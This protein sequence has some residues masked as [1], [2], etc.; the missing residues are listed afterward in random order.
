MTLLSDKLCLAHC[1]DRCSC[2]S[3]HEYFPKEIL[4]KEV[5]LYAFE[6]GDKV[7]KFTGDYHAYGEVRGYVIMKNGAIRY[8]VEHDSIPEGSFLHIYSEKNIRKIEDVN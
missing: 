3:V 4:I 5:S 7:I 2:Q 1:G 6:I 8:V